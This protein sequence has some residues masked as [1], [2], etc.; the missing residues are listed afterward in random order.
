M[1]AI[2]NRDVSFGYP[3]LLFMYP[4]VDAFHLPEEIHPRHVAG[5]LRPLASPYTCK[6]RLVRQ[7]L[8]SRAESELTH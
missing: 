3:V 4:I 5:R 7:A 8:G 1:L 2:P 6:K